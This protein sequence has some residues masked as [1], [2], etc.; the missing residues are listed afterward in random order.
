[1]PVD[2]YAA[3]TRDLE[4]RVGDALTIDADVVEGATQ[5]GAAIDAFAV[6]TERLR[7]TI[8]AGAGIIDASIGAAALSRWTPRTFTV[9]GAT[10]APDAE[11]AHT[12]HDVGAKIDTLA[13]STLLTAGTLDA[14]ASIDA[15][16]FDAD[17]TGS[18]F[19][20]GARI[21]ALA[22]ETD[23]SG[24]TLGVLIDGAVAVDVDP[25][26]AVGR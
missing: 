10:L 8:D 20:I 3:G 26:A 21:S 12:A 22:V 14:E 4:A 6:A 13:V 25:V 23:L 9:V 15:D 18:A 5:G 17:Q 1:L 7:R 19:V 16:P 24:R 11:L 2:A